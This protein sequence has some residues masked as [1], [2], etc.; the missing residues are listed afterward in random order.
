[1]LSRIFYGQSWAPSEAD[2][3]SA[4]G[5]AVIRESDVTCLLAYLS[6][7]VVLSDDGHGPVRSLDEFGQNTKVA[8][9]N[10]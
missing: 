9:R 10:A 7:A 5:C 4:S 2:L 6:P 8:A 1:M 3:V